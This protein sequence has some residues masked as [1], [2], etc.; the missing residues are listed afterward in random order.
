MEGE[1]ESGSPNFMNYLEL[2]KDKFK[3]PDIM[4]CLDS[5]CG[6]YEKLWRSC[7]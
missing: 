1:E 3:V 2:I 6:N 4:I 5:V 7:S